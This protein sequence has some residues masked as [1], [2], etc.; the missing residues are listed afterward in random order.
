[1]INKI[2]CLV[3]LRRRHHSICH[4][5]STPKFLVSL[6]LHGEGMGSSRCR[7]GGSS[8]LCRVCTRRFRLTRGSLTKRRSSICVNLARHSLLLPNCRRLKRWWG[9]KRFNP[10]FLSLRSLFTAC[11]RVMM[12]LLLKLLLLLCDDF[13]CGFSERLLT[14]VLC[15][16]VMMIVAEGCYGGRGGVKGVAVL[17]F[18]VRF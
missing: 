9:N 11:K 8:V 15:H 14:G 3:A 12:M 17:R 2:V 5:L 10:D 18:A 6:L 4:F 1:M 16:V 13:S 7:C